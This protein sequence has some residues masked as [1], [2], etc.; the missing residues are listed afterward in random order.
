MRTPGKSSR[1]QKRYGGVEAP[2]VQRQADPSSAATEGEEVP[3]TAARGV[4]GSGQALPHLDAIQRS[5]GRH[6][7]GHVLAHVGG[8][9]EE[10]AEQFP[11][12]RYGH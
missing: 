1:V 11:K 8:D 10:F 2:P 7:V 4:E 6:D 3:A 9:A 5:F 12:S